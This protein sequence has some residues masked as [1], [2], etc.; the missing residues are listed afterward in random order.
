MGA[1][2]AARGDLSDTEALFSSQ[3]NLAMSHGMQHW[4]MFPDTSIPSTQYPLCKAL[5]EQ[6]PHKRSNGM[7][8]LFLVLSWSHWVCVGFPL[9]F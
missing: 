1:T 9:V 4:K 7:M 2:A 3:G 8:R 5:E 6:Y